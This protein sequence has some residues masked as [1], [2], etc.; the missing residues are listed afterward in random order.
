[1]ADLGPNAKPSSERREAV[2]I[3]L[4]DK[5]GYTDYSDLEPMREYL[6]ILLKCERFSRYESLSRAELKRK[7]IAKTSKN[8]ILAARMSSPASGQLRSMPEWLVK[9]IPVLE[10][11]VGELIA[12]DDIAAL[13]REAYH[14]KTDLYHTVDFSSQWTLS[15]EDRWAHAF[16]IKE[17]GFDSAAFA[18]WS[19][20]LG[21]GSWWYTHA[22]GISDV[23]PSFRL[24]FDGSALK[25][26]PASEVE[27]I[28]SGYV[29]THWPELAP[30]EVRQL[31]AYLADQIYRHFGVDL[32]ES[33]GF[34]D[35]IKNPKKVKDLVLL[36]K[37]PVPKAVATDGAAVGGRLSDKG[38]A[39]VP[40]KTTK[41]GDGKFRIMLGY[42][43][44][45]INNF[46][47]LRPVFDALSMLDRRRTRMDSA[48]YFGQGYPVTVEMNVVDGM[49]YSSAKGELRQ[50]DLARRAV[51]ELIKNALEAGGGKKP[52]FEVHRVRVGD[53]QMAEVAV[54]SD[55]VI[56]W[57]ALRAKALGAARSGRLWRARDSA[58]MLISDPDLVSESAVSLSDGDANKL[59]ETYGDEVLL[60]IEN[61][62]TDKQKRETATGRHG[63][64]LSFVKSL[65]DSV[66]WDFT[67]ES[68]RSTGTWFRLR[69]PLAKTWTQSPGRWS[70]WKYSQKVADNRGKT[71]GV[72]GSEFSSGARFADISND[73]L[74]R[75]QTNPA[76]QVQ[77]H[78]NKFARIGMRAAWFALL[79][80]AVWTLWKSIVMV[81][82]DPSIWSA[83]WPVM[84]VGWAVMG[85]TVISTRLQ[86]NAAL[87]IPFILVGVSLV[88]GAFHLLVTP[89]AV[90]N[91]ILFPVGIALRAAVVYK[92]VRKVQ[93]KQAETD[94][95]PANR[96]TALRWS[97]SNALLGG[98]FINVIYFSA[99]HAIFPDVGSK[100]IFDQG[101]ASF[102]CTAW[103]GIVLGA[104]FGEKVD[105]IKNFARIGKLFVVFL[106]VFPLNF[107]YWYPAVWIAWK[108]SSCLPGDVMP[109]VAQ[110]LGH[111]FFM[112]FWILYLQPFVRK[113]FIEN[114]PVVPSEPISAA[115]VNDGSRMA[116][117]PKADAGFLKQFPKSA[118]NI[119]RR[120][121]ADSWR[122]VCATAKR[123]IDEFRGVWQTDGIVVARMDKTDRRAQSENMRHWALYLYRGKIHMMQTDPTATFEFAPD[124]LPLYQGDDPATPPQPGTI[125]TP[126][127]MALCL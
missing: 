56:D 52:V 98:S 61:L 114:R 78:G 28:V 41:N 102:S 3:I 113:S 8:P 30:S 9:I 4:S 115:K 96:W 126:R 21:S 84:V 59:I 104:A 58:Y 14:L 25:V 89:F 34:I 123:K 15:L 26:E 80:L 112:Y 127:D 86:H 70:G 71:G 106:K 17:K 120:L 40:D 45:T 29:E 43:T 90:A 122:K 6:K 32:V 51:S 64:G 20:H 124:S 57:E 13:M 81:V 108:V 93:L 5:N 88:Y 16:D 77:V 110:M 50:D 49:G 118:G 74:I 23:V 116:T 35:V 2:R 62:S 65:A 22:G 55:S 36:G 39:A 68:D 10:A 85:I 19:D 73:A 103:T 67:F 92:A 101:V 37:P 100:T 69:F 97:F 119:L 105:L 66:G 31:G 46:D 79:P 18:V 47:L 1:M 117:T 109:V 60:Y 7:S 94:G 82:Q 54:W 24:R 107:G 91:V 38:A 87:Q 125:F 33:Y 99:I 76:K 48:N 111:S 53:R 83:Y 121:T 12:R 63:A 95:T 44:G 27:K 42:P 11:N 75:Q 72:V